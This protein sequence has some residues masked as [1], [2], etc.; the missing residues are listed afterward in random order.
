MKSKKIIDENN[1]KVVSVPNNMTY[2][3]QPLDLTVNRSCK[4]FLRKI[5]QDWYS[6]EMENEKKWSKHTISK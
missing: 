5:A 4:V 2:I 3:F 6:N 1:G